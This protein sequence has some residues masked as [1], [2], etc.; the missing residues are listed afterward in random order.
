MSR[1]GRRE[2]NGVNCVTGD[3]G[4]QHWLLILE[5]E[6]YLSSSSSSF[7]H[8]YSITIQQQ[9]EKKSKKRATYTLN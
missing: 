8:A 6:M 2:R 4:F 9:Y 5:G 1:M 7:I 3:G